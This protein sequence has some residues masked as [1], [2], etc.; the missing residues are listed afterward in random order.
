MPETNREN[1]AQGTGTPSLFKDSFIVPEKN[2]LRKAVLLPVVLALHAALVAVLVVIPLFSVAS[3][4]KV[5]FIAAFLAPPPPPAPPKNPAAESARY[6]RRPSP[7]TRF[8]PNT[9][10]A[11]IV[12]PDEII[13][14]QLGGAGTE[15]GVEGGTGGG[16]VGGQVGGVIGGVLDKIAKGM[17]E[18]LRVTEIKQPRL[19]KQVMPIYPEVARQARVEG[20]VV[21]EA[22]TDRYGRV[23]DVKIIRS[24]PLL[25]Q[26]TVDAVSQWLYEPMIINGRPR[27]VIFTVTATFT[28]Q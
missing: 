5:E 10:V 2:W 23:I 27:A 19:V 22:T 21:V 25:D 3:A 9:L 8:G 20:V 14:E 18:P 11:P 17:E 15:G 26:A 6:R 12:V 7:L 24:I 1:K 16:G 28:L 13:E 4:P